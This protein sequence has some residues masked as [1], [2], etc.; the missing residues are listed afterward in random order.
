MGLELTDGT[1]IEG[2]YRLARVLSAGEMG[3]VWSA[4]R[5]D[6]GPPVAL[7]LLSPPASLGPDSAQRLVREARAAASVRHPSASTIHEVLTLNDG[8]PVV[9]TELLNGE[10][11]RARLQREKRLDLPELARI[12]L[13]AMS[14]V[15]S[16][17]AQGIVHRDLRPENIFLVEPGRGQ[18][19]S[20]RIKVLDFGITPLTTVDGAAARAAGLDG[21]GTLLGTPHYMAPE[22]VLGAPDV[23]HRADVWSLGVIL[24]EALTGIR[25]LE[26]STTEKILKRILAGTVTKVRLV[27]PQTPTIV[28]MMVEK[29]L[30]VDREQ[31]PTLQEV[32]K[33]LNR[34][35]NITF[36]PFGPPAPARSPS[37]EFPAVEGPRLVAPSPAAG[38]LT[39]QAVAH[40]DSLTSAVRE[41]NARREAAAAEQASD[42]AGAPAEAREAGSGGEV[43]SASQASGAAGG[44]AAPEVTAGH[45]AG[46]SPAHAGPARAPAPTLPSGTALSGAALSGA[47]KADPVTGDVATGTAEGATA[48]G[49]TAAGPT[50]AGPTA[51]AAGA[52]TG[53]AEAAGT[54]AEKRTGVANAEAEMATAVAATAV[55]HEADLPASPETGAAAEMPAPPS[56]AHRSTPPPAPPM[57]WPTLVV[58][59]LVLVAGAALILWWQRPAPAPSG[60]CPAGM[61]Q[62]SPGLCLDEAEVTTTR[63][64]A[65]ASRGS[66]PALA[67]P[68]SGAPCAGKASADQGPSVVAHCVRRDEAAALCRSEGKRLPSQDE[69]SRAESLVG[70]IPYPFARQDPAGSFRCAAAPAAR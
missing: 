17:H 34:F 27:A 38:D 29:M 59:G 22:Q 11:L 26:G 15:G 51:P 4:V 42:T 56:R 23:D 25:P 1:I 12:L 63:Y 33:V 47:V 2:R 35:G 50:A 68:P 54:A 28:A 70:K 13:P 37:G 41:E 6:G 16:A 36:R 45:A 30:T 39:S 21:P 7:K 69:W 53:D 24:Y 19:G 3:V 14:A 52:R 65:C 5:L 60:P 49:P 44:E 46:A 10:S 8:T 20:A 48:A 55:A 9:V 62:V 67:P 32:G 31:R 18:V 57:R 58:G 43:S 64:E 66:C 40:L 61:T